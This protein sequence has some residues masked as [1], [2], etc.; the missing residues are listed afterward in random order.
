MPWNVIA[1]FCQGTCLIVTA[2]A[3]FK[4]EGAE[5]TL[6]E[7]L[8]CSNDKAVTN[9]KLGDLYTKPSLT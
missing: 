5:C 4:I 3:A 9:H 7:L 6:E 8:A 1:N 2:A